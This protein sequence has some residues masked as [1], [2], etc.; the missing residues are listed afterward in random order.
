MDL[1]FIPA[2]AK[3]K[4]SLPGKLVAELPQHVCL[5]TASQFVSQ[6]GMVKAS[7][8]AGGKVVSLVKGKHAKWPG[9]ILGCSWAG[10]EFPPETE[11]F[12]YIGDGLFHPKALLL[13]SDKPVFVYDPFADHVERLAQDAVADIRRKAKGALLTFLHATSIGVLLSTKPGQ[14][15]LH[16][17]LDLK[18]RFPDKNFYY[19]T[20]N[21]I[22]F[23]Q[24]ENFPFVECFV[25]TSCN[26]IIDDY[27]RFPKPVVNIEDLSR[28]S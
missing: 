3:L 9:Q 8:E 26:R 18:R 15:Q 6:L 17:A 27:A 4:V 5:A 1:F 13:G 16:L 28:R 7:L 11:A 23:N 21:T 19:L 14:M 10:L 25:N 20:S 22:E 12:L 2:K 24:M